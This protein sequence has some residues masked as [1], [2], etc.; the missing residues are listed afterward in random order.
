ML[1]ATLK[2]QKSSHDDMKENL[3]FKQSRF[4]YINNQKQKQIKNITKGKISKIS[5]ISKSLYWGN[6]V[7]K[8]DNEIYF[9]NTIK[10]HSYFLFAFS[11]VSKKVELLKISKVM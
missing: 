7:V 5:K 1:T 4:N 3:H 8:T 2:D 11:V 6:V 10:V 9:L